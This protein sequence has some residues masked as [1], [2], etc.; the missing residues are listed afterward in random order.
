MQISLSQLHEGLF[1]LLFHLEAEILMFE[2]MHPLL[3]LHTNI[4]IGP[5]LVHYEN[6]SFCKRIWVK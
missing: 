4:A 6:V 2:H 3:T 1:R 5:L